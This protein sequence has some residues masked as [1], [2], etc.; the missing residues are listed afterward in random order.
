LDKKIVC[1][2]EMLWDVFPYAKIA[3]GAPMNVALHLYHLGTE[4]SLIS[5]I[6]DDQDG[7]DL[8]EFVQQYG[9]ATDQISVDPSLPTGRVIVDDSDKENIRY[10]IVQPAAWDNIE[11]NEELQHKVNQAGAFIFGS[12]AA[13]GETSRVTLLHLLDSPALKVFDINLRSPFYSKEGLQE[14]LSRTDILKLNEEELQILSEYHGLLGNTVSA[15][16]ELSALYSLRMICVTKGK[17]G[18]DLYAD[19]S[20]LSHP[21]FVVTVEDTVGSGDAFLAALVDG[22]LSGKRYEQI[23]EDACA[24]GALVATR[25]GGTPRYT[26]VDIERIKMGL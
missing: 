13:R 11:W 23:L 22:Y 19:N 4:V 16:K 26:P 17:N 12:L 15:M 21:G 5:R 6:G 14:L 20:F 8:L 1:F 18:A 9:L 3:G 10:K 25:K 2:G 24:L 7:G